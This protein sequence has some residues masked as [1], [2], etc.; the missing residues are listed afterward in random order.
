MVGKKTDMNAP[1]MLVVAGA[2]QRSDGF[3]LMHQRPLEKHHGGLWEFPGGKV[4]LSEI[5]YKALFRELKEELGIE[6]EETTC[7][8]LFFAQS[9]PEPPV[10]AIVIL[11]YKIEAWRGD[12]ASLEGGAVDWFAPDR[13]ADLPRPPLDTQLCARLFG[14]SLQSGGAGQAG[15]GR[16][17][18]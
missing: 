17:W 5:P 6:I 7:R 16:G 13:I 4:E 1:P 12:P 14:D 18:S 11:L 8:P 10:P 3:W 9:A 15:G 2:L